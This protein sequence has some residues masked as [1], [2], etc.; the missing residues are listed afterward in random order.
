MSRPTF[1]KIDLRLTNLEWG[2]SAYASDQ[3]VMAYDFPSL[4]ITTLPG[5]ART[6]LNIS[7]RHNSI[8]CLQYPL[9]WRG[10]VLELS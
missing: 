2:N 4:E 3:I 1:L 8:T 6:I 10:L 5:L 9:I 7:S